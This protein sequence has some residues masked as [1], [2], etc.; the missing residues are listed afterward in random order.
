MTIARGGHLRV[1][2][3]D[4]RLGIQTTNVALVEGAVNTVLANGG[5]VASVAT[6]RQLLATPAAT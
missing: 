3:E 4:A 1:G 6:M 5:A 2:L